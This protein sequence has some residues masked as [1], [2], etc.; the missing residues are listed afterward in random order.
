MPDLKWVKHVG[1]APLPYDADRRHWW[2]CDEFSLE[3]TKEGDGKYWL[4]CE[5]KPLGM[6]PRLKDAKAAAQRFV[7]ST[8]SPELPRHRVRREGQKKRQRKHAIA[9]PVE[10]S[11]TSLIPTSRSEV[12]ML[13]LSRKVRER[14]LVRWR[15]PVGV[16]DVWLT[17]LEIEGGKV[18][19]G[20]LAPADVLIHREETIES[21]KD[22]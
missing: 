14:I 3:I 6:G 10:R 15:S 4:R 9:K 16:V 5:K 19:L 2:T 11:A 22:S 8:L 21:A 1:N 12:F 13:V 18:R 7:E 17:V 20:F